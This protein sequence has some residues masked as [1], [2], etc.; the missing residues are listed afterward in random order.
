MDISLRDL[1]DCVDAD[2]AQ[3]R[4]VLFRLFGF[5]RGRVPP[6]PGGVTASVSV[7][8]LADDLEDDHVHLNVD[9]RRVRRPR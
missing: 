5:R 9:R 6:D 1:F 3:D 8:Q 4:S 2:P 7:R